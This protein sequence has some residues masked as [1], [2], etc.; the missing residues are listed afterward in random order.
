MAIL[1]VNAGSS[2]LKFSLHPLLA[3]AAQ[4]S[5]LNGNV[6]GLEPGGSAVLG[7]NYE[8]QRHS[9]Q[10]PTTDGDPFEQA[11]QALGELLSSIPAIAKLDAIVIAQEA[12]EAAK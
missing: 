9:R 6:E 12:E 3:G 1:A 8:G 2:S 10:L 11:L 5:I 4:R 7:W